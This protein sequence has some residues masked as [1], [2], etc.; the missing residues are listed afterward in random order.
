MA[1]SLPN[2]FLQINQ[3]ALSLVIKKPVK[4]ASIGANRGI[5]PAGSNPSV[6]RV[7]CRKKDLHPEFHEDAKVY[8]NGELVMTTGGTKMLINNSNKLKTNLDLFASQLVQRSKTDSEPPKLL[9]PR[10]FASP[11]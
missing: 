7:T 2:S 9:T 3:C 6:V 5:K 11:S 1:V 10:C 8:C 4:A